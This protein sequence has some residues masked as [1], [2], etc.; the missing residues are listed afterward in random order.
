MLIGD[1]DFAYTMA[2]KRFDD[3]RDI[4]MLIVILKRNC[5]EQ[6]VRARTDAC[7]EDGGPFLLRLFAEVG[8]NLVIILL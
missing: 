3:F 8:S 4:L 7:E 6:S 1:V 2:L 5:A